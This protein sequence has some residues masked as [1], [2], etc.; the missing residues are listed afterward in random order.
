MI[1][2]MDRVKKVIVSVRQIVTTVYLIPGHLG[3][4]Y[5]SRRSMIKVFINFEMQPNLKQ[6]PG[7]Y[8]KCL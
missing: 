3:S 5:K 1:I 4:D 6:T 7:L 2:R 8:Y